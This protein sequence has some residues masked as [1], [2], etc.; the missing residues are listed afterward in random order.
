MIQTSWV[1]ERHLKL[2]RLNC[3]APQRA[4]CAFTDGTSVFTFAYTKVSDSM[5]ISTDELEQLVTEARRDMILRHRARNAPIVVVENGAVIVKDPCCP[6]GL[7]AT[8]LWP[9]QALKQHDPRKPDD[10]LAIH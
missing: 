6:Y 5:D 4:I 3:D 9:C 8:S 10:D 2:T 7:R 1:R